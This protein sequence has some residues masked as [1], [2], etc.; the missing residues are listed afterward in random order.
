MKVVQYFQSSALILKIPAVLFE[1][2]YGRD[3]FISISRFCVDSCRLGCKNSKAQLESDCIPSINIFV[4]IS[5]ATNK[6]HV[7]LI[8]NY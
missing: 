3:D 6:L 1:I 8:M 4:Q 2:F 7:L 5:V